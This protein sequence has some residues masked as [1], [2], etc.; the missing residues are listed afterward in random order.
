MKMY[1]CRNLFEYSITKSH[2]KTISI[3][4]K[5]GGE[6]VVK[7]P[8]SLPLKE[9]EK[10]VESKADWILKKIP[11]MIALAEKVPEKAYVTG[12]TLY[13]LGERYKLIRKPSLDARKGSVA[14]AGDSIIVYGSFDSAE[15]VKAAL[16]KWYQEK[17]SEWIMQRVNLYKEKI[18][19]EFRRVSFRSPKTRW[20][21]CSSQKNL[22]INWKLIMAP[23]EI[24]DYVVCHELCHLLEMN[25]SEDFWAL[26]A[27][28]IPDWKRRRSWLR[29]NGITLCV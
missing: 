3:V 19:V 10:C 14:M 28:Q 2:R 25:H 12:E 9:I 24:I 26:V 17:A 11:E 13:F 4:I 27:K 20:G 23:I 15:E 5:A 8:S 7:A 6:V 29:E 16:E 22:M 1:K 21:S 18:G